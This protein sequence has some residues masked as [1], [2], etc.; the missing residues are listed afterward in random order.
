MFDVAYTTTA[1]IWETKFIKPSLTVFNQ[2]CVSW[3]VLERM[4]QKF[5]SFITSPDLFCKGDKLWSVILSTPQKFRLHYKDTIPKIRNKYSQTWNCAASVPIPTF[6][7]LWVIYS[8][9]ILEQ[10]NRWTH[11]GNIANRYMNMNVE[12]ETDPNC[13][14]PRRWQLM[15]CLEVLS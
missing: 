12:I 4:S 11:G 9:F 3:R 13:C 7:Y 10:E 1:L 2:C 8:L 15:N 14:Q 6:I 5:F